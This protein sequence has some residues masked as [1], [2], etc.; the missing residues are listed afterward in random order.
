MIKINK[1]R[2]NT[3]NNYFKNRDIMIKDFEK[4]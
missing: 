4:K 3:R 1:L 2:D